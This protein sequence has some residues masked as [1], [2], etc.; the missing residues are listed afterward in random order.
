MFIAKRLTGAAH[1]T[2]LSSG[3]SSRHGVIGDFEGSWGWSNHPADLHGPHIHPSA[4]VQGRDRCTSAAELHPRSRR[5]RRATGRQAAH[6]PGGHGLLQREKAT[7]SVRVCLSSSRSRS[8]SRSSY[9][10]RSDEFPSRHR[11][12]P[13]FLF[14]TTWPRRSLIPSCLL[15]TFSTSARSW[16]QRAVTAFS[17]DPMSAASC[18]R[19]P[20][21][22]RSFLINFEAA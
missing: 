19:W 3:C 20:S 1:L 9:L 8:S 18:L 13:G 14:M 4:H 21:S 16:R 6:E 11:R 22:S 12:Q 5:S 17:A 2:H 10:L 15:L 7:R